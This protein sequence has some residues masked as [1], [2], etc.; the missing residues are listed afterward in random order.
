M[1]EINKASF[2][3]YSLAAMKHKLDSMFDMHPY[4][5]EIN[6]EYVDKNLFSNAELGRRDF[7]M[8]V[9][10]AQQKT[11]LYCVYCFVY[12]IKN[13][14]LCQKGLIIDNIDYVKRSIKRHEKSKY[15]KTAVHK[16]RNSR[17]LDE[18]RDEK[19]SAIKRNRH[20]VRKI[21]EA[22]IHVSTSGK[23]FK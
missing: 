13:Y 20:V 23:L 14:A 18:A 11:V 21:A 15:H 3:T 2:T 9:P 7:L 5:V 6:G 10:N 22:V 16:Y 1:T 19:K 17:T 4:R 8:F 12:G